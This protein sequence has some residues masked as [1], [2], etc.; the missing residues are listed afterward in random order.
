[1]VPNV[2]V[3]AVPPVQVSQV[4]LLALPDGVVAVSIFPSILESHEMF[5]KGAVRVG[6][7]SP[8]PDVDSPLIAVC[9]VKAR[10]IGCKL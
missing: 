6:L 8:P 4:N 3:S 7:V 10:F 2:T 5:P 9:Y 1:M